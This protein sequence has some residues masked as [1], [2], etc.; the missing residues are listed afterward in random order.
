M[1]GESGEGAGAGRAGAD[2]SAERTS[3][4]AGGARV[5]AACGHLAIALAALVAAEARLFK[6][7]IGLVFLA[8]V[9]LLAFAVSL[10]A[11]AVAL[12]GWAFR[13]ATGSTGIALGLL[14]VL[15]LVLLAASWWSIRKVI[16]A[17]SFPETRGELAAL[18][19][20]LR[21]AAAA[22]QPGPRPGDHD[23]TG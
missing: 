7:N 16:R 19:D 17:A 10:W 21:H 1:D 18:L 2:A 9:A 14:V 6:A 8:G 22:P 15:H 23:S 4:L 11:C 5:F 13:V 20:G 3:A 12:I